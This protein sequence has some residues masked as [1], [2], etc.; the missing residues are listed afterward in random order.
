MTTPSAPDEPLTERE[1][2]AAL[3]VSA[4]VLLLG[5]W[6]LIEIAPLLFDK[7]T[8]VGRS[9]DQLHVV[10][11]H[12]TMR[13][14][15]PPWTMTYLGALVVA[16]V[17]LGGASVASAWR[18]LRERPLPVWT[19]I[20]TAACAAGLSVVHGVFLFGYDQAFGEG[21]LIWGFVHVVTLTRID[22][23]A[24]EAALG[25]YRIGQ[26]VGLL[27]TLAWPALLVSLTVS[28]EPDTPPPGAPR[29]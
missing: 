23:T 7:T 24:T 13:E 14:G 21:G 19:V 9:G 27:A 4:Y 1:G 6:R 3:V 10:V 12:T 25:G 18:R 11:E 15:Y 2:F 26:G 17:V 5:V 20:A 16:L 29:A 22:G 28:D 8:V